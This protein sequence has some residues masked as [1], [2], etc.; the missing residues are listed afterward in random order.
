[1]FI[2]VCKHE[3]LF[4]VNSKVDMLD[5]LKEEIIRGQVYYEFRVAI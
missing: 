4:E 1:M 3:A 2:S 5:G